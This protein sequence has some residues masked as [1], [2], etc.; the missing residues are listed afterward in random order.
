[1]NKSEE[2][3]VTWRNPS[4]VAEALSRGKYSV[5]EAHLMRRE[6]LLQ[7]KGLSA[8]PSLLQLLAIVKFRQ[9]KYQESE[10]YYRQILENDDVDA[11]VL[12]SM[13]L[14]LCAQG[15]RDQAKVFCHM[16]EQLRASTLKDSEITLNDLADVY[17]EC[18]NYQLA[19]EICETALDVAEHDL[20]FSDEK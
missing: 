3:A 18:G 6:R 17:C 10:D 9:G 16:A 15:R 20:A 12:N 2:L 1:M 19:T 14:S 4:V 5:A 8:P 13:G 7:K 11:V